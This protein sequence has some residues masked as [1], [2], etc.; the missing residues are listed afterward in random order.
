MLSDGLYAPRKS[1]SVGM[2]HSIKAGSRMG[3]LSRAHS[4][5]RNQNARK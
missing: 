4:P 3:F 1:Q 2:S 5:L